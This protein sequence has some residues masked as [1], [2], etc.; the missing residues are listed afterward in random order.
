MNFIFEGTLQIEQ[1]RKAR[2]MNMS[3][4]V[5]KA[6][7]LESG[8]Y[9]WVEFTPEV[10]RTSNIVN[11]WKLWCHKILL[12]VKVPCLLHLLS[13]FYIITVPEML[14]VYS[15]LAGCFGDIQLCAIHDLASIYTCLRR[16]LCRNLGSLRSKWWSIAPGVISGLMYNS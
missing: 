1:E 15:C 3:R 4:A 5:K 13:K 8:I 7:W 14:S 16:P 11:Q 2:S 10:W 9:T 6:H 12:K